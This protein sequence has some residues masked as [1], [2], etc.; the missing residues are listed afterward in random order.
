MSDPQHLLEPDI[1]TE[2]ALPDD[3]VSSEPTASDTHDQ[4]VRERDEYLDGWHRARADFVNYKK[5]EGER[6]ESALRY[7]LEDVFLDL[8]RVID[9]FDLALATQAKQGT[10]DTGITLIRTQLIDVLKRR[11][12]E[13]IALAVGDAY[14]P[15]V[16]E[17]IGTVTADVPSGMIA[18][19][20]EMGYRLAGRVIRP[21]KVQLSQ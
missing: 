18:N 11:G 8:L 14:D 16:A 4:L 5:Q 20:V 1:T 2:A 17:A 6:I 13:P 3:A 10:A 9:S 19:V 7:G 15:A 12:V 21:A